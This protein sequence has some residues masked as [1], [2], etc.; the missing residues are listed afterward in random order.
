MNRGLVSL[1]VFVCLTVFSSSG[2][3]PSLYGNAG[4]SRSYPGESTPKKPS[5]K[6][7]TTGPK[8]IWDAQFGKAYRLLW[9]PSP[10]GPWEPFGETVLGTGKE[11][12]IHDEGGDARMRFYRLEITELIPPR[13]VPI[14]GGTY[15]M[16][17]HFGLDPTYSAP[18]H[19]VRVTTFFM[20]VT[21]VTNAHFCRYLNIARQAGEVQLGGKAGVCNADD[22]R[23]NYLDLRRD[24]FNPLFF[25]SDVL[26]SER[27]DSFEVVPGREYHP[28]AGVFW[29][30]AAAYCNWRSGE[31]GLQPCY[32][33]HTWK[34]NFEADGYRL[35]TEAEWEYAARGALRY[36]AYPWGN[37]IDGSKANYAHSGDPHENDCD[38]GIGHPTTPVASYAP[39]RYGL[40]DMA[41]NVMEFCNE[42]FQP[43]YYQDCV[44]NGIADNP[45]GPA[46]P[47]HEMGGLS[48]EYVLRGGSCWNSPADLSCGLHWPPSQGALGFR[49][50][51]RRRV[52]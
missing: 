48:R 41:G 23:F 10:G 27:S 34:C 9:G 24:P 1:T 37:E 51:R 35:P 45:T 18:V 29:Y 43:Y 8:I 20:D 50:V 5:I 25:D 47:M 31:E 12:C 52:P 3:C 39:N 13:T 30:G 46:F 26:Y 22:S 4:P 28:V 16:G 21:E 40:Y 42:Y 11:M 49:C 38:L 6:S 32:D 19:T 36:S 17:D 14:R 7:I 44:E 15:D 33:L 2:T